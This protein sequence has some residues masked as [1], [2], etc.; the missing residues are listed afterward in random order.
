MLRHK[1]H[2]ILYYAYFI[3]SLYLRDRFVKIN[4]SRTLIAKVEFFEGSAS[5]IT[6]AYGLLKNM[7]F[8]DDSCTIQDYIKKQ[9]SN[10]LTFYLHTAKEQMQGAAKHQLVI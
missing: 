6:K 5:M 7:P 2:K 3:E 4:Q 10:H 1:L 8:D 9:L